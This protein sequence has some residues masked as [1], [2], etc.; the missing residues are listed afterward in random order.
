M[1]QA[2]DGRFGLVAQKKVEPVL[3]F[4]E[5]RPISVFNIEQNRLNPREEKSKEDVEELKDSIRLMG[6]VLVPL[7]VYEREPGKYVL[8]DGERRW[9]A[10]KELAKENEEFAMVPANIIKGPLRDLTN[11]VAMFNIHMAREEWST[12]ARYV[13]YGKIKKLLAKDLNIN[14]LTQITGLS[15]KEIEEAEDFLECPVDLQHRCLDSK[16]NEYYLIL[17]N[18]SLRIIGNL[19]PKLTNRKSELIRNYIAKV[20]KGIIDSTRDAVILPRIGRDCKKYRSQ[21]LFLDA[22]KRV[23]YKPDFSVKDA[24]RLVYEQLSPKQE[25]VFLERCRAFLEQT[26]S[27]YKTHRKIAIPK[28][29]ASLMRRLKDELEKILGVLFRRKTT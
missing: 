2:C 26:R 5:L 19:Y 20:D 4:A 23:F 25:D 12:A 29:T 10:S 16:L 18:R 15:E 8:L 24:E 13:T 7:V 17:L 22:F 28:Q 1:R 3:E 21:R 27:Y 9:R 14:E 11:Y 6:R